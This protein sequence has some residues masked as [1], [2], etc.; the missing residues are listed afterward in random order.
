MR[1]SCIF[2]VELAKRGTDESQGH[3]HLLGVMVSDGVCGMSRSLKGKMSTEGCEV[4]GEKE[5]N[6]ARSLGVRR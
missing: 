4:G 3:R 5:Q 1:N 6:S 2:C